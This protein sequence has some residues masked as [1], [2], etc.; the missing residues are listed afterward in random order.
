M[1]ADR[2]NLVSTHVLELLA[3]KI[4]HDLVSPVGAIYNGIEFMEESGTDIADEAMGLI[5]HSA[6]QASA[7]LAA[8]RIVYTAG[9]ASN[10]IRPSSVEKAFKDLISEEKNTV[11]R[12]EVKDITGSVPAGFYKIIMGCLLLAREM[13]PVGG[14][15]NVS[16]DDNVAGKVQI[17]VI[18]SKIIIYE[19]MLESLKKEIDEEALTPRMS[20]PYILACFADSYG[21][22]FSLDQKSDNEVVITVG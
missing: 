15:V 18:G 16:S 6:A 10:D 3:S 7:K 1:S 8:F 21:V 9:G 2:K 20:H 19:G 13:I 14:E 22:N 5:K 4:C 17:Q 11:F 12:W